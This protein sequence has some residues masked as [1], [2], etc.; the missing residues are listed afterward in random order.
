MPSLTPLAFAALGLLAE[1]PTHPYEMFQT[2]THRRDGRNVKVRPGTLY[3][4]VGRLV[5]LGLAEIVGTD[6]AGNRPERTTYAITDDG[7]T[8]LHDGLVRLIAEPAEEYPV[9]HLAVAEIENLSVDEAE[10]ALRA[11]AVALRAQRDEADEILGVVRA[12]DLPERYWL[13]VSYV[14]AMLTTQ[15]EWLAATADRI[16]AGHISWDASVASA[17]TTTNSKETTR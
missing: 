13:D 4:Q 5:E 12:K 1:G 10:S 8:A 7:W 14:R 17:D 15:I 6:R 9:F 2:M 3:H 16:A 11:R